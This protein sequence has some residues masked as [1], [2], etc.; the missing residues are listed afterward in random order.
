MGLRV[1]F[2]FK[3]FRRAEYGETGHVR[4]EFLARLVRRLRDIRLR[5]RYL[6][7]PLGDRVVLCLI[8]DLAMPL[9]CLVDD[10]AGFLARLVDLLLDGDLGGLQLLLG[11]VGSS[12][13]LGDALTALVERLDQGRPHELHAEPHEEQHRDGL[14]N[15][16]GIDVHALPRFQRRWG[17]GYPA[18]SPGPVRNSRLQ[19]PRAFCS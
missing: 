2:F 3:N 19:P 12:K 18:R 13:A 15:Q 6:P 11:P 4:A 7:L 14:V 10:L 5:C 9:V 8:E 16:S 1:D 17:F